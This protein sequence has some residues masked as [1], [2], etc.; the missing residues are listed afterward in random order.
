MAP[1]AT[2][3]PPTTADP[4]ILALRK[5][6]CS[7]SEPLARRF[8]ALFSLKHLACQSSLPAIHAIAAAFASPSALLKHELA[9][10]LGQT[11]DLAAVP[12]LRAVL[13]DKD[14]DAMC[15]H[16]AAEALGAI[17]DMGSLE[18]LRELRDRKE[19]VVVVRETCEI[20][21]ARIE[22]ENSEEGKREN[23]QKRYAICL[24]MCMILLIILK[25]F[26]IYRPRTN[27]RAER[28]NREP[29]EEFAGYYEAFVRTIPSYVWS[30]RPCFATRPSYRSPCSSCPSKGIRRS[31]RPLPT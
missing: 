16:E 19:E 27:F 25:R 4:T 9:Y 28:I 23:L 15:R 30:S 17:G 3:P 20:A 22:W 12:F 14:E 7:E 5:T 24:D 6:L 21:V 31:I 10:C 2:S 13:E 18:L 8:R 1:S 11:K 26:C 29:G